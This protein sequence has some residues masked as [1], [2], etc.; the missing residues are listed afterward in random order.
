MIYD[1]IDVWPRTMQDSRSTAEDQ[2][3]YL[4]CLFR[5]EE[6]RRE[7]AYILLCM[8]NDYEEGT[9]GRG[10]RGEHRLNR[11]T[12]ETFFTAFSHA[13]IIDQAQTLSPYVYTCGVLNSLP[14][15]LHALPSESNNVH[16]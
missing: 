6:G 7:T 16:D 2:W 8:K 13:S 10:E 9:K 12:S 14:P 15:I 5:V 11:H 1:D 4:G 3:Q